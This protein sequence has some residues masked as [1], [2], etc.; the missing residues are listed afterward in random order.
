MVTEAD[1]EYRGCNQQGA[2][3]RS[4]LNCGTARKQMS[5]FTGGLEEE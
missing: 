3:V 2:I 5:V 4:S 1:P